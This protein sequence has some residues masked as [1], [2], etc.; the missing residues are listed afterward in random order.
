[1]PNNNYY[2]A[3]S[4]LISLSK[5]PVKLS[6]AN[7]FLDSVFYKNL[8][9]SKSK[10]GEKASYYIEIIS[11]ALKFEILE[12]GLEVILNPDSNSTNQ[13]IIPIELFYQLEVIKYINSFDSSSFDF[14]IKSYF[15]LIVSITGVSDE[16]ILDEAIELFVSDNGNKVQNFILEY[17]GYADKIINLTPTTDFQTLYSQFTNGN[18][19]IFEVVYS[20]FIE[21]DENPLNALRI[22]TTKKIGFFSLDRLKQ[23]ITPRFSLSLTDL[24]L[25]LAFPRSWLKPLDANGNVI[26]GDAKSMLSYAVGNLNFHSEN[27]FEFI[28]PDS[29]DLSP[30]QIGD[31]GLTIEIEDLKFDFRTDKNIPEVDADRRPFNFQGV[32][33]KS[34]TIGLGSFWKKDDSGSTARLYGQNLIIGTGGFSGIVG[35]DAINQDPSNTT[36]EIIALELAD[37]AFRAELNVFEAR[38]SKNE[39]LASRLEGTMTLP[40]FKDTQG[41][42][43]ELSV[44]GELVENGFSLTIE[45][46]QGI[47]LNIA[48]KLEIQLFTFTI[49]RKNDKWF[50]ELKC[51]L[52]REFDLPIVSKILPKE[53]AIDNIRVGQGETPTFAVNFTWENGFTAF[54]SNEGVPELL[55][56]ISKPGAKPVWVDNLRVGVFPKEDYTEVPMSLSGGL[57]LGPVSATVKDVGIKGK[58]TFPEEGGNFGPININFEVKPPTGISITIEASKFKGG[59]YLYWKDNKY[60]GALEINFGEKLAI[61]AIGILLTEFPDGSE[62]TSFLAILSAEFKLK[63]PL[64]ITLLGVGGMIGTHRSLNLPA[65]R[66]SVRDN[67]IKSVLFPTDPVKNLN[68]VITDLERFFPLQKSR[69]TFGPMFKLGFGSPIFITAEL[70]L[71]FELPKPIKI[72]LL[73]VLVVNLPKESIVDPEA[74]IQNPPAPPPPPQVLHLQVNFVGTW[75]QERKYITFDASLYNSKLGN[76]PLVGDMALR[77]LYGEEPNFLVSVGGFHPAFE[78]PPLDLPVMRR[79]SLSLTKGDDPRLI[80]AAYMAVTS[81]TVQVGALIDFYFSITEKYAV[82]GFLG[83]DALFQFSPFYFNVNFAAM[84]AVK[85]MNKNKSLFAISLG[86]NLEGPTPWRAK[87]YASFTIAGIPFEAKIDK[88]FGKEENTVLPDIELLPKVKMELENLQN[89]ESILPAERQLQVTLAKTDGELVAHPYGVLSVGQKVVPLGLQL[90]K[91]GHQQPADHRKFDF[92]LKIGGNTPDTNRTQEHFAP[93]DFQEMSDTEKLRRK[94]FEKFDAGLQLKGHQEVKM[95]FFRQ[96]A[97]KY[98][99]VMMTNRYQPEP[100][101]KQLE[102]IGRFQRF[103]GGSASY[104]SSQSTKKSRVQ[105]GP[106]VKI[107]KSG[108]KI[109]YK[110]DLQ[111]YEEAYDGNQAGAMAFLMQELDR[112]PELEGQLQVVPARLVS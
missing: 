48:D 18:I 97:C 63:L 111:L 94:S 22:L 31:T 100:I 17:N 37:G 76:Y 106:Q 105:S 35:M 66:Q 33:I 24:D 83:F 82:T 39:V 108:Y 9:T 86:L 5:F 54:G 27:G 29:F 101:G 11:S 103:Q 32:F 73:G 92:E 42:I 38:F 7:D 16:E 28:N 2:P 34:A 13:S 64:N 19:D 6:F 46:P 80:L 87:G 107:K 12:T 44:T 10:Y 70:G 81:N 51:T 40:P 84:L 69:H 96:R 14:S 112:M 47:V 55:I 49:G 104:I 8:R 91:Y 71:L 20:Y 65:L 4:N 77:I 25:V 1:M 30:S 68:K 67:S 74:P 23:L 41:N 61:K 102:E 95:S 109:V 79:L 50:A 59:G 60:I 93:A 75:E 99:T 78:V 45:E 56:P 85:N 98:E 21:N 26:E 58:L 88:T 43:A 62:G 89:W 52:L 90:E 72:A 3:L 110:R 57:K 53:I 15:E 36:P